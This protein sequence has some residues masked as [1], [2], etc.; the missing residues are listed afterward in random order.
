VSW[1]PNRK[2][3]PNLAN[4]EAAMVSLV[5]VGVGLPGLHFHPCI[6]Q[7]DNSSCAKQITDE[8]K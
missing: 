4:A 8:T 6:H 2:I 7:S 5:G 3:K 1:G